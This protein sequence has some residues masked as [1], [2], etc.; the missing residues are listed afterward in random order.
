MKK[1]LTLIAI[2]TLVLSVSLI[3]ASAATASLLPTDATVWEHYLEGGTTEITVT[4]TDGVTVVASKGTIDWPCAALSLAEE[5]QITV[6]VAGTSLEYDFTVENGFSNIMFFMKGDSPSGY[7]QN[8]YIRMVDCISAFGIAD[9]TDIKPGTYTGS[10]TLEEML[11]A[12]TEYDDYLA[13][14]VNA[15]GTLTFSGLKIYVV[16]GAV[17][18]VNKLQLVAT[19]EITTGTTSEESIVE[20]DVVSSESEPVSTVVSEEEEDDDTS[21]T[22]ATSVTASQDTSTD[23]NENS[24]LVLYIGIP[25]VVLAAIGIIFAVAK[26]KK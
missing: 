17:V 21:S 24:N 3:S 11:A 15:D 2:F 25:V 7:T 22:V 14:A 23:E 8:M 5:D 1:V 6:P 10:I 20:S 16:S 12:M 9:S 18:T 13:D 26:K 4:V 19:G